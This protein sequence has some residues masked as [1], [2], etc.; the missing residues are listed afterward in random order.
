MSICNAAVETHLEAEQSRN[1]MLANY[2]HN[3]QI[4]IFYCLCIK[5]K[6]FK[7]Y[8]R[9][10]TSAETSAVIKLKGGIKPHTVINTQEL[11]D[12]LQPAG[13]SVDTLK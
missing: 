7:M 13:V 11:V 5:S 9:V 12:L 10:L 6:Q 2:I 8:L 3:N 1:T 4:L